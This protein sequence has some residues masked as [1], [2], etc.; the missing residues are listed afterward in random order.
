MS[1]RGSQ[2]LL[3]RLARVNRLAV[4]LVTLALT[5]AGFFLPGLPGG[6]ILLVLAVAMGVLLAVT[7]PVQP[8]GQR[9]VRLLVVA[10][11]VAFAGSKIF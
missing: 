2:D 7:W 5:L 11:L 1:S 10:A 8:P 4:L 6:L 3:A 9:L